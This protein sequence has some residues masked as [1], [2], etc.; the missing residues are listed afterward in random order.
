MPARTLAIRRWPR[1]IRD[2]RC[3]PSQ[4][5]TLSR[6][7]CR[8]QPVDTG[9]QRLRTDDNRCRA[10]RSVS[11]RTRASS[12]ERKRARRTSQSSERGESWRSERLRR[13]VKCGGN[14]R[15]EQVTSYFI[16]GAKSGRQVSGCSRPRTERMH[17]YAT[18]VNGASSH[19]L[20]STSRRP[21]LQSAAAP[22]RCQHCCACKRLAAVLRCIAIA[23]QSAPRTQS[24]W[25]CS[26]CRSRRWAR[27]KASASTWL[28]ASSSSTRSGLDYELHAMG[29]I[30]EGELDEVLDLMRRCIEQ[31][32]TAQRPR[33]V[34]R[35]ARFPPRPH[36]PAEK[37][38]RKRRTKT[39]PPSPKTH[40]IIQAP[41]DCHSGLSH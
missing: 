33:H 13:S 31:V 23:S 35:Q 39:R 14:Q 26:K 1:R 2:V 8:S 12:D 6:S 20:Q 5:P 30:V 10:L 21:R 28:S 41:I 18:T 7:A 22:A 3:R 9:S 11:Q 27:A 4:R 16:L 32:A 17:S 38:S 15:R 19:G 24:P 37:Q 25:S 34:R 40:R 29:T 36:R